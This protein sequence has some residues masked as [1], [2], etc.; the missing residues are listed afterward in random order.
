MTVF[1]LP[2]FTDFFSNLQVELPLLTR[3]TMG[4]SLFVKDHI[5]VILLVSVGAGLA[6]SQFA[7]SETGG[8]SISR[9][10]LRVPFLGHIFHQ[11]AIS[12]FCR[13]LSTLLAGG[14]PL[15]TSLEVAVRAISNP[16][17]QSKLEPVVQRV[18]EGQ[19][20][21]ETLDATGVTSAIVIDMV[22][23]GEATGELDTML[24]DLS[25]FLDEEVEVRLERALSL[26]EPVM[27]VLMGFIVATLLISVYLP[28]FSLLGQIEG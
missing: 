6:A 19:A 10:K 28:L 4:F 18:R 25:D 17:L 21:A 8:M 9:W 23:V 5:F 14:I 20:L 7:R 1:V 16:F 24:S 12:E 22:Q 26:L 15:V 27:L 2:K 11:S 13:S 3:I